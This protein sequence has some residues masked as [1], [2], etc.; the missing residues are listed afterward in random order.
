M[1]EK[2]AT[3]APVFKISK[4]VYTFTHIHIVD[5]RRMNYNLRKA[6]FRTVLLLFAVI[7]SSAVLM[8]QTTNDTLFVYTGKGHVDAFPRHLVKNDEIASRNSLKVTLIDGSTY[9]YH[10]WNYDSITSTGPALP[11]LTSFKFNNKYNDEMPWDVE[12]DVITSSMVLSVPSIT[13]WLTPSFKVD[14]E[15]AQVLV[16]GEVQT[17]KESR[18]RFDHDIIYSTSLPGSRLARKKA[19][20]TVVM[21]PYGHDYLV[22]IDFLTESAT[23]VPRIDIDIDGGKTV[24]SKTTYRHAYFRLQG[25][26]VYEDMED[27]V[28]I[29]GRGNSS[30]SWPK[31]PYR[32]KFN[33][34]V[35][36][37]GLTKGKSWVLLSN[38]QRNS[39]MT[40]AIGMKAARLVGTAGANHIIPVDLYVNGSY[41]GSYNFTEKV[42][43]SNNSI[44]INDT[45]GVML[46]LD[47]YYDEAYKFISAGFNLPVNIKDPDLTQGP[48]TGHAKEWK[49]FYRTDFD[50][51]CNACKSKINYEKYLDVDAFAKFLMV[52]DLILNLELG[53]PKSTYLYNEAPGTDASRWV[54][55]P[56]WDLDWGFGYENNNSY[57]SGS[58]TYSLFG[59]SSSFGTGTAFFKAMLNNSETVK[60]AYYRVW[61]YF[62]Q[63]SWQ[64][65]IDYIQDYYDYAASSFFANAMVWNDGWNYESS[66]QNI[67]NWLEK[68][69]NWIM[70]NIEVYDLTDPDVFPA[71]VNQDVYAPAEECVI[72]G[73]SCLRIVAPCPSHIDIRSAGGI[74]LQ[75][76]DI[77]EGL[78]T[79]PLENGTYIVNNKKT[80]IH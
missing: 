13:R 71:D 20:G 18:Q 12:A 15:K 75:S 53:H 6:T 72:S 17:S 30:W 5:L 33:S 3:F 37:F 65:L 44:D 23:D 36:P 27:S 32:L 62:M 24:T 78:T 61:Y 80:I 59:K 4:R 43:I 67:R 14:S 64:E 10:T 74:L 9:T 79:I 19:D 68:R 66:L 69:T 57:Y 26:D 45:T 60:K 2:S 50:Q 70:D 21:G 28:W 8:A 7:L 29:K 77:P 54:F 47:S 48:F 11:N 40:N 41:Q 63:D 46:E 16:D 52:N 22:G 73:G 31:K 56:V 34:K 55:G 25:N 51:L 42:G 76:L 38:Y 35:K 49:D 1:P 58:S 39:M